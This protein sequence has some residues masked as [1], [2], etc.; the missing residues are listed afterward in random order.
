MCRVLE[1]FY[2]GELVSNEMP[3]FPK[4]GSVSPSSV[5]RCL[6]ISSGV[7]LLSP[8]PRLFH[9]TVRE[10]VDKFFK[11]NNIVSLPLS[12]QTSPVLSTHTLSL[13]LSLSLSL[14]LQDPKISYWMFLR[15]F[16]FFL[17]ANLFWLGMVREGRRGRKKPFCCFVVWLHRWCLVRW[18]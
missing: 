9:R 18:C 10:R 11:E 7:Y 14:F 6:I 4:P 12:L 8:S 1:K 13:S 15:Y 3:V 2:V 17:T 16:V 5:C